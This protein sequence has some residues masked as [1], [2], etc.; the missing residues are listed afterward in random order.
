MKKNCKTCDH[1]IVCKKITLS[2]DFTNKAEN[3]QHFKP[4]EEEQKKKK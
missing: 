4:Y 2:S 1:F 3:C